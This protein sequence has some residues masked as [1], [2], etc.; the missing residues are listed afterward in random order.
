MSLLTQRIVRPLVLS[1]VMPAA[2]LAGGFELGIGGREPVPPSSKFE[3]ALSAMSLPAGALQG[4]GH[5]AFT[6]PVDPAARF[7]GAGT[8]GIALPPLNR[9]AR[10][11]YV[12]F[13]SPPVKAL[14]L[15]MTGTR[16]YAANTPAGTLSVIET[17]ASGS[18]LPRVKTEIPVG[19]EPVSVA[20]QPFANEWVWVA[21]MLS[22]DVT[23]VDTT[24]NQVAAVIPVGD[25]PC[26]ILFSHDGAFA[27]VVLQGPALTAS[28]P[29]ATPS[30]HLVTIDTASRAV[31]HTL[32][33]NCTKPRAAA[34]NPQR[35]RLIVAALHSGNN[36]A[37]VGKMVT[38]L[39]EDMSVGRVFMLAPQILRDFSWTRAAFAAATSLSPWPDQ[40]TNNL[41]QDAPPVMRIQPD[42]GQTNDWLS[43]IGLLLLPDGTINPQAV[44]DLANEFA[45]QGSP[46]SNAQELITELVN[47]IPDTTDNDLLVIDTSTPSAPTVASIIPNVGTTL[48][49][50]AY[51]SAGDRI[52]VSNLEPNNLIRLVT[53]LKGQSVRNEIVVIDNPDTAPTVSRVDLDNP[54]PAPAGAILANPTDIVF[55]RN[56]ARAYVAALGGNNIGV[57][58]GTTGGVLGVSSVGRGPRSLALDW[59]R[60]RLY[61]FNRTDL[62][63]TTLSTATPQPTALH[64]LYLFNPESHTIK[65]GRNFLFSA[66]FS[67]GGHTS[68]ASCHIDATLDMTAWDLGDPHGTLLPAPSNLT[69][70]N[71]P[72][73]NHPLKGPMITQTLRGLD[74]HNNFHWR[75]DKP[76]L[77]DFNE[78]FEHLL[79]GQQ[80][81][82]E[83]MDQ[84]A[85]FVETINFPPNP[86]FTRDSTPTHTRWID[87]AGQFIANCNACH[88][89]VASDA[90]GALLI[91]GG[92]DGTRRNENG[93]DDTALDLRGLIAQLQ[94]ITQLRGIHEKFQAEPFTGTGTIH[95]A[96]EKSE[97]NGHPLRTF[98]ITFFG[99]M[100][101]QEMDDTITMVTSFPTNVMP[102]VGWQIR[103]VAPVEVT[104]LSELLLMLGLA[105]QTPAQCD[106]V[107]FRTDADGVHG[108]WWQAA[109]DGTQG[110]FT[111]DGGFI[112]LNDLFDQL[113]ADEVLVFQAVT[114]GSGRR[115]GIDWDLDCT[116]NALDLAPRGTADL[117][118]DGEVALSDLTTLL[119]HFGMLTGVPRESGDIDGDGG[120]DLRDLTLLLS[121]F[122]RIC[123]QN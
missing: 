95:D 108:Y 107:A 28:E 109:D 9:L 88:S 58:D 68:C 77:E 32:T 15:N 121:A 22:D 3:Q 25:E 70:P 17:V 54:V 4:L 93:L 6:A 5:P 84:L 46:L 51:N 119:S 64:T 12:N 105:D 115:I 75:G 65:V 83:Q 43:I 110:L 81:T 20:V 85:R 104:Q 117:N 29:P 30:S 40:T 21:N 37:T 52:F 13:E 1:G 118:Q 106:V 8:R 62:S 97:A 72:L 111:D 61:S 92:H 49:G 100:T 38:L 103:M 86:F 53:N 122:G 35:S 82:D 76:T 74:H 41:G 89:L 116:P 79:G 31:V 44:T 114:P 34:M 60:N 57:L 45:I 26:N 80:L 102:V 2:A 112:T 91:E 78:A 10:G 33:L 24:T 19:L 16:L 14:A 63:I 120:V 55:S 67:Q 39:P 87:G 113:A 50:L 48:T 99:F 98:L 73:M 36:T 11:S 66:E 59:T 123:S 23:V 42:A 71:G 96:R 47:M 101:P 94:E 56:G 27:Y 7:P 18:G 90:G 69:T